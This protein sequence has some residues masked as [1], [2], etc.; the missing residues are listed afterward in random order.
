MQHNPPIE[1]IIRHITSGGEVYSNEITEWLNASEANQMTYRSI[2]DVWHVA[3]NAPKPFKPDRTAAWEKVRKQIRTKKSLRPLYRRM[4]QY[5]AAILIAAI[6]VWMGSELDH[7]KQ[8]GFSEISSPTGHKTKVMLPDSSTVLLNSGSKIRYGNDYNA[9]NR[10]VELQGEGY[11]DIRKNSSKQFVVHTS[12]IDV[13]VF[14]TSFNVKAYQDEPNVEVGL[15]S[16]LV[17]IE[18]MDIKPVRINPGELAVLNK[19]NMSLHIEKTDIELISSWTRNEL[20]FEEKTLKEIAEHMERWYGIEIT[21][22]PQLLDDERFTFTLKT[23]SLRELLR[24]INL[25][26]PIDYK[27]EGK[28]VTITSPKN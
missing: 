25:I 24:L 1:K 5:A 2:R 13:K 26:K 16:G 12:H 14:G 9:R 20:V 23:E 3:A 27:I 6:C 7:S 10:I 19:Q 18:G 4:T 21:I 28:Q 8:L 22:A 15:K 17:G 11:F